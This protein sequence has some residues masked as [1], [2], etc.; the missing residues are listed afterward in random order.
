MDELARFAIRRRLLAA[1]VLAPPV[2][3]AVAVDYAPVVPRPLAFPRDHGAHPDFRIE[4]WYL[5]ALLAAEG[6][7]TEIGVQVTFF[8]LRTALATDNPSPF[9]ARQLV[10]AHAAIADPARGALLHEQRIERTGPGVRCAEDDLRIALD[11]WRFDRS[12]DGTISGH[13]DART[14]RID[15]RARPRQPLLLQ[16]DQGV[17]QKGDPAHGA[18]ASY[19]YSAPQLA[20]EATIEAGGTRRALAGTAW[21]D[22]EWSSALLPP[23]AAG[24]DWAG[25]NLDDGSSL[26]AFRIRAADGSTVSTYAA[27][28]GGEDGAQ[29][30]VFSG[31]AVRFE[32]LA[33]WE[34]PRTRARYP[35]SMRITVGDRRFETRPLMPDQELDGRASAGV[36]YWEGAS[37]VDEDGRPAGRGYLELT[38]YAE[39]FA[40]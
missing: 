32:P 34:S 16:G 36:V 37:R 20:C 28:R 24:W 21:L 7:T 31:N 26:T 13:I 14:L 17:S 19:Y 2:S 23:D 25:I 22:H 27:L 3:H 8:R 35:V 39:R 33:V 6:G 5:T 38:G 9:T 15:L 30:T 11:A 4:W 1:A 18:G 12:P 10:L 40:L 29:P